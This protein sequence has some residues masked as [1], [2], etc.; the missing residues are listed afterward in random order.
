[1][2]K[3]HSSYNWIRHPLQ[4]FAQAVEYIGS[5]QRINKTI[6]QR[7]SA[8]FGCTTQSSQCPSQ[9]NTKIACTFLTLSM[10]F[11]FSIQQNIKFHMISL[12]SATHMLPETFCNKQ[13]KNC[14]HTIFNL[15]W[16][17]HSIEGF[18]TL[19]LL[20]EWYVSARHD[21]R[22]VLC[23]WVQKHFCTEIK[24]SLKRL[25]YSKN[26]NWKTECNV[27]VII[28]YLNQLR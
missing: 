5:E 25:V 12:L 17:L 14:V 21:Y 9:G 19:K 16:E 27:R 4:A 7:T 8:I 23:S 2:Y 1:M 6:L 26:T 15:Q 24:Y 20:L 3:R 11:Y 22:N 18:N 10:A 13:I 28:E